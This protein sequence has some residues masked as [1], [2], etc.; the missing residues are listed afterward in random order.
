MA[1]DN[2]GFVEVGSKPKSHV[3]LPAQSVAPDDESNKVADVPAPSSNP[4]YVK[5]TKQLETY[6]ADLLRLETE[7]KLANTSDV[8][9][10]ASEYQ[11]RMRLNVNMLYS[12]MNTYIDI[13]SDLEKELAEKRQS[14]F[15]MRLAE[16]KQTPSSAKNYS[17][18]LTR[19]DAMTVKIVQNRINQ[20][21][22]DYE[23]Y[24]G[25]CISLQSTMKAENT[26]RI[27][28]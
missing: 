12:F 11:R 28:G 4:A 6:H 2:D 18:E 16:P 23:R 10:L 14:L 20:I 17:E 3:S 24:N 1:V 21:K 26:E 8:P 27:M 7:G 13:L 22:N 25:I 19:V 5:L 9:G 15:V